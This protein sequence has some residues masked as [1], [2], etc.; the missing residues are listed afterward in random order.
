MDNA[1]KIQKGFSRLASGKDAA[2]RA[3]LV[4]TMERAMR[5]ALSEH[6]GGHRLHTILGD[7]YGWAVYHD[8]S[9]TDCGVHREDGG[10]TLG[11]LRTYGGRSGSGWC[12]ILYADMEATGGSY[13]SISYERAI[14][15][16]TVQFTRGNFNRYFTAA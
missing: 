11:K 14:M 1:A 12:G 7:N 8:G 3:C 2:C 9:V 6:D 15:A 13:Y 16:S 10:K 5:F 4:E